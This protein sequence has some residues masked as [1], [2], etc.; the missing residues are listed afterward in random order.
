M[1]TTK[2]TPEQR[3][4]KARAERIIK[5]RAEGKKWDG[6]DG[7]CQAVGIK[8]AMVGRALMREF[9]AAEQVKPL[10]GK[11]LEQQQEAHER[12]ARELAERAAKRAAA[13]QTAEQPIAAAK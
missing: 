11:R 13:K 3:E 12:H 5:L 2:L 4:R 8:S 1:A 7:I 6:D 10:T 9:G